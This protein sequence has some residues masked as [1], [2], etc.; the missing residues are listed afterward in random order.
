MILCGIPCLIAIN[1][2]V[3]KSRT[4]GAN[5]MQDN[6]LRKIMEAYIKPSQFPGGFPRACL[7]IFL[8]S[9]G[10]APMFF[11][12]LM[13]RDLVGITDQVALQRNFSL[14]SIDFFLAAAVAASL[15]GVLLPNKQKVQRGQ[16]PSWEVRSGSFIVTAL[17]TIGFGIVCLL[18]PFV[19][20]FHTQLMRARALYILSALLGA[21]FGL[22]FSRF[23]DCTWQ[24]LP[25]NVEFANAMGFS[26][27]WK[28]L[29][30][31]L[32]N[33]FSGLILDLCQ[34]DE[35]FL[36]N[37]KGKTTLVGYRFIG[38]LIVCACSGLLSFSAAALVFTIP[39]KM[40]SEKTTTPD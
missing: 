35:E 9:S 29:G 23:Q 37:T 1:Q 11:L 3:P 21:T 33:F 24:L 15:N 34:K 17:A 5:L 10:S 36:P 25:P 40:E 14:I 22:V 27:M 38:Y 39:G 30:A 19:Y 26:T 31:G 16:T 20:F 32:G 2:D 6:F 7:C 8:F 13:L 28:L 18:L 12:L 4:R